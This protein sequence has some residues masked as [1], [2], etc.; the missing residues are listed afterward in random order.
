MACITISGFPSSGKT[1]RA[2]QLQ[3]ALNHK[4]E[5][6]G[7]ETSVSAVEI[8][9]D[10]ILNIPRSSYD[11]SRSEKPARS[12][13]LAAVVRQLS[14]NKILILDGMNYIKGYRYQIYCAAREA[15]VRVCTIHVVATSALCNQWNLHEDG[16][17]SYS[18]PTLENLLQ[19][20]EEPSSMVRW[21][22]PLFTVPWDEE[23]PVE[24]IWKT[25][26]LGEKKPPNAAVQALATPPTDALQVLEQTS[27][28]LVTLIMSQA[29]QGGG[30][31]TLALPSK[32]QLTIALPSRN[33]T[34]SELQRV[35]RQFIA[36][37]KKALSQSMAGKG[38][39][40][41]TE[42]TVG[43]KFVDYLE[44]NLKP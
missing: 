18:T 43:Q 17:M 32:L 33:L 22:S 15:G 29:N 5:N 20:Y 39:L 3:L 23:L 40:D 4:I 2:Q 11:D 26:M 28:A 1:R 9:S 30:K 6:L 35:K 41:W 27:T 8:I 38:S 10:D 19:R 25:I 21:D 16:S 34:L 12:S 13:Y 44:E 14:K 42:G 36:I 24:D 31:I 37:H 7:H